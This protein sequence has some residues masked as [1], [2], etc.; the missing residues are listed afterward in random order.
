MSAQVEE[1]KFPA[2][3]WQAPVRIW[4]WI[5]ALCMVVLWVTGYFI[6]TPLPSVGGE[7]SEH[8]IMGYIR[9]AHFAAA[10]IFAC[11]FLFRIYWAIVGNQHAKEIF[12]APAYMLT[13]RW[14]RGF[15]RVVGH[16]LF[17]RPK[18]DWHY[19]HNQLAMAA[20][21]GMFVLGAVFM[22]VTGFA[23]YGEGLGRNSWAFKLFS[24]WVI[25]LFGQSQDVHT[26]HHMCAWYLFW[27]TMVHLYFVV[28]EDI[29]SGLTVVSSMINGWRDAKN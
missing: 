23:L 24:S 15:F 29:T 2:Y 11:A 20:M 26:W 17:I 5:M 10:Y 12:L 13:A 7:A 25:P 14:W 22:I 3:I 1:L 27:F 19:G 9:F 6:G 4:H 28:R 18:N 8:F 16:Y 21:F